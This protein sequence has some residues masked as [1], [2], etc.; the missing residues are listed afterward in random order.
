VVQ[1]N[2]KAHRNA[3]TFAEHNRTFQIRCIIA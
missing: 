3:A 1:N 2:D